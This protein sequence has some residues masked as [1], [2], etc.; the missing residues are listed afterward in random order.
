MTRNKCYLIEYE[1]Y[2]G[3]FVSFGDGKGRISG[4]G[5]IKIRTLDF[6]D[7]YFCKELKYN[8]F[9][10]SQICDK[11]NNVLF[12]DTECLV[13][14]SNFKLLDESQVLLRVPRKDNIYSVDLKS[15]V[16]TRGLTCL[17]AK[18]TT[19][20]SNLWHMRLGHI[21][22]KTMNKLVRENLREFSVSRTLQQNG[23]AERKNK[24]LIEATPYEIIHGRP[25]LI[26]FMKP[27]GYP[28]T[29][30]RTKDNIV[31]DQAEKKKEPEQEYI[32]IPICTT[33]PLISQGPK[34]NTVDARKKATEVDASQ[35]SNNG[36]QDTRSDSPVSTAR[37]SFV[38]A[39]SPSPINVTGTPASTNEFEEHPFERFSL[40]K[41]AF[42][43]PHVSIMTPINDTGI[44]DNAYDNEAVEEEV[45]MNN[46]IEEDVYVYQPPALKIQIFLTK[47]TRFD[48]TFA[49]CVC[50]RFQ[51]TPKTL[52]LYDVK[53]IFRYLKGQPKLSLSY[54]RDS[55][56]DL[57]AY[58]DSDYAGA[59]LN[60][61][62]TT[63]CCQFLGKRLIS[64]QCK[65]Q[66]I[67]ANSTTE[68]EYIV[69]ASC[70]GQGLWI[71]NQMLDYGFNLMNTK[72]YIDNESTICIVKNPVFHSKTKHIEIRHHFIRDLFKKKLIQAY[73][74]S[75]SRSQFRMMIAKDGRCFMDIFVVKTGISSFNTAGAKTTAW[76][77]FS[78]TMASAIICLVNNQKFNFSKY[79]F[80]NMV[81]H[82]DGGVKFLM[83]PRFLQV[84]LDKQ[85]EGMDKHKEIYV[86]SSHTKKI[87]ANMSR[88][89][90]GFSGNVTS[91]FK[92]MMVIPQEKVGEGLAEV[93]S[94]SSKIP[95]EES[96][97]TH[98][99]D[100]LPSGEYIIQLNEL[101]IFC[102]S[103][104]QQLEKR[105]KSRL[106]G[107]R[108]LKKVGT[109]KQ[110]KSSKEKNSL[111][112][113]EDAS[114][115]GRNI[116]DI[117][118]DA[119]IALVDEAQGRMHDVEMFRV[120][121]LE[122]NEVFI[123]VR[124]KTVEKEVSTAD[125]VTTSGE[126]V[127]A[128]S[129]KDSDAPTTATTIDVDDELTMAKNLIAIK[130]AKPKLAEQI[131]AQEREQLSIEERSKLL[132]ELIE[133]RRKYFTAKRAEEIRIKPLTKAQQRSL[134]CTY[135]R[136]M[137]GFK[138]KDFKGKSFNDIK[139]TFDKVYKRVNTFLDMDTENVEE[140]LKK[141]EVEGSS[142]R[143]ELKRC[144]EIVL[145]DDDNVAI[146]ATPLSS[147]SH[148][149][150]DYKI[151][152][153][154]RKSYFRIIRADGNS[155]NYL[156]F[157]TMF[158][159]FNREDLEVLRSII[160]EM[161]KKTKPVDDMKNML[162][163]TLKTMFEPHI[164]DIIWKY[165]QGAVK[166]N[167]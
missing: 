66:T 6:D 27:F 125:P 151:Y 107:L 37:P 17:F 38:N 132:A 111:G 103:L 167:N 30:L 163:Q 162:F 122:G 155:Q 138:Q 133:S 53:R 153:E 33:D 29:I 137:E 51:V 76:N 57:E 12:T 7:V 3:G 131:Q 109:S 129:V 9:S 1:D 69:A 28:V 143:A 35:V 36:G 43:L 2:D 60:K 136:N 61:N 126:V 23:V 114:K 98:F 20:E 102:T 84:F 124:E 159:N 113:K 160:K 123:D 31:A 73:L 112:A 56:F 104:R 50:V 147:K 74:I 78:S 70:C 115:Q 92:T 120:D 65:K 45:D 79:I 81:K 88:Q 72:I 119:E 48:I 166:V 164:E 13:L 97:P 34:D 24:T 91:L 130:A 42:S 118:Q 62:S 142:K 77:E 44:F 110:V 165:Q 21:N 86:M 157:R 71:Q 146:K 139:K 32:L 134:M 152:K 99:D 100:P 25:P 85:V 14:S 87:F 145:E 128:A 96:V 108:R 22:Y 144:L 54:P 154:E 161:F 67:V 82:L 5:K 41:N 26:D 156:T 75:K 16:P 64:W 10:M 106:A 127:T 18:A 94:P 141:T 149:I 140:S 158:K 95:V 19:D 55:P 63:G 150:V 15:V 93:H 101:M 90:Q 8:L 39:A 52:H 40:F 117:D 11:K 46:V 121:D 49:V 47:S 68:A 58:S 83:F 89:G 116:K 4:K 80:D 59:S 135:M 148:T 105:R